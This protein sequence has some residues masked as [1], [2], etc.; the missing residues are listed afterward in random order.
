MQTH[1]T[2]VRTAC[3]TANPPAFADIFSS[4]PRSAH[5]HALAVS[6]LFQADRFA[7]VSLLVCPGSRPA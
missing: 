3:T 5:A 1:T 6:A 7:C 4:S 2:W